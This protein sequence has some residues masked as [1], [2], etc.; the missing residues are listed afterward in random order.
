MAK[1][2]VFIWSTTSSSIL[3]ARRASLMGIDATVVG[4]WPRFGEMFATGLSQTDREVISGSA[5][6]WGLQKEV[7]MRAGDKAGRNGANPDLANSNRLQTIFP[8]VESSEAILREWLE[9][10]PEATM[11]EGKRR[12]KITWRLN[13]PLE[14]VT[15]EGNVITSVTCGGVVYEAL[16]FLD[17]SDENDLAKMAGM[18]LRIGRESRAVTGEKIAG[19]TPVQSWRLVGVD[20]VTGNRLKGLLPRPRTAIGGADHSIMAYNTRTIIT[21]ADDRIP[22]AD[23]VIPGYDP[24]AYVKKQFAIA[25]LQNRKEIPGAFNDVLQPVKD[26]RNTYDMNSAG[27]PYGNNS[28]GDMFEWHNASFARRKELYRDYIYRT[29]GLFKFFA[30]DPRVAAALPEMVADIHRYGMVPGLWPD[31]PVPGWPPMMYVRESFRLEAQ[32]ML[33]EHDVYGP[34]RMVQHPITTYGYH[35]DRHP[36]GQWVDS[37]GLYVTEGNQDLEQG[38]EVGLLMPWGCMK[39]PLG[40]CKNLQVLRGIG[41]TILGRTK[42]R[43]EIT[44][45][46]MADAAAIAC[47]TAEQAG[48]Y[49]NEIDYVTQFRPALLAAGAVLTLPGL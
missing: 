43:I 6:Y 2:G 16:N 41:G 14:A 36:A 39:P 25:V 23:A 18:P 4:A 49:S 33:T 8:S 35:Q 10:A 1:T 37:R 3:A 12:G 24:E 45:F 27:I 19:A 9:S 7:Y 42:M 5:N 47:A 31:S 17:G 34:V 32:V 15:M 13:A 26:G 22:F 20:P 38:V 29:A 48:M 40:R 30:S 11:V 28:V 46:K 44:M 21:D